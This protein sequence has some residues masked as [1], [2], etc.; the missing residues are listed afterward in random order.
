[1]FSHIVIY[2]IRTKK[3]YKIAATDE[4]YIGTIIAYM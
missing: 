2:H 1:M 3:R 4:G